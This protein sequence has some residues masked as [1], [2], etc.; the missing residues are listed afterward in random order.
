MLFTSSFREIFFS[1]MSV[2][3][4]PTFQNLL[5][6]LPGWIFARR[7]TI[8]AMI[9][10]A[11]LAGKRHHSTFHRV[12]AAARWSMDKVG[13]AVFKLILALIPKDGVV[14]LAAD[15]TLARK[16]G[17]KIFGVG[18]H[19]DP[20]LSS[21]K[22]AIV[23]WGHN[24]VVLGVMLRFPFRPGHFFCLPILFRLYRNK[25]T[26][27]RE[28]GVYRTRPE[29]LVEMLQLLCR[30]FQERRFHLVADSSYS[31]RSVALHLP[32]NCDF[33]GRAHLDAQL[34][35]PAPERMPGAKG[36]PRK[37]GDRLPSPRTMLRKT[38]RRITL[39]IYGRRETMLVATGKALWYNVARSRILRVVAVKPLS[40]GRD[41]QAFYSTCSDAI[42]EEVLTWYAR[43]WSIET[44]FQDTKSH[45]GF[46]EPQGWSRRAVERTAPMAMLLY[47][48]IV[49]WFARVGHKAVAFP[50]RP[51]YV[52]KSSVAFI[53]M[54]RTLR[55]ESLREQ[56]IQPRQSP[57][58]MKK[59]VE[60][61]INLA[62]WAA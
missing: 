28:R 25:K 49:I 61:L 52:R 10:A 30:T 35:A 53:D 39:D 11:G 45:L 60:S 13:L 22:K 38:T 16:R 18:M 42:P 3:T 46:E 2:M 21:R 57:T 5:A 44:A 37:R 41:I 7:R 40:S 29:L 47:S 55:R 15:D 50:Y 20:L 17:L 51:W 4:Q 9:Q 26:T 23:S 54:L 12:F 8:T 62:A 31:G 27:T 24:W 56:F 1:L 43:R 58:H 32:D 59:T 48:M 14:F 34:Y 6:L 33:T 19:H 36:R